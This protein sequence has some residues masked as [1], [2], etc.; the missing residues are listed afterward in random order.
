MANTGLTDTS[1]LLAAVAKTL[2]FAQYKQG[3]REFE[4]P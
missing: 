3:F 4:E 2:R 1:I